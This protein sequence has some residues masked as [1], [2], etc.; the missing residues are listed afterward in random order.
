M[1]KVI[2]ALICLLIIVS[3]MLSFAS[4]E[5]L[6]YAF[7]YGYAIVT[8]IQSHNYDGYT[9]GLYG[10]PRSF[11]TSHEIHWV[12]TFDEAMT[13][14]EHLR[15]AG[16]V[17]PNIYISSYENESVDAK[18]IFV[19]NTG[20]TREQRDGEEWYERKF[21]FID[22]IGYYGF[23]EPVTIKELEYSRVR[24]YKCTTLKNT[25]HEDSHV[26]PLFISYECKKENL[27]YQS[28]K[29]EEIC[30][31]NDITHNN[32][33]LTSLSYFN[34]ED[35]NAELPEDFHEEFIKSLVYIGYFHS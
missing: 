17:I 2:K 29:I 9:G 15:A 12:E 25:I 11:Y 21:N 19:V 24:Q 22:Q 16:N 18:Y 8:N 14:I 13:V 27:S 23:L 30:Y 4:C 34:V 28:D 31:F 5:V 26:Q 1:K 3:V 7:V 35:H 20:N 32:Y 6:E 33:C 10:L